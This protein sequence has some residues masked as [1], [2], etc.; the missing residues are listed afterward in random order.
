M[1]YYQPIVVASCHL[2]I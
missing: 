2:Q 1:N